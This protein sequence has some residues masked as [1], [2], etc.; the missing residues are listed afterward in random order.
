MT[1]TNGIVIE[2]QTRHSD[3]HYHSGVVSGSSASTLSRYYY[4]Y[5]HRELALRLFLALQLFSVVTWKWKTEVREEV[6]RTDRPMRC[7]SIH[8][9]ILALYM[10][11]IIP[12]LFTLPVHFFSSSSLITAVL[13]RFIHFAK[14]HD[15]LP[16]IRNSWGGY[17]VTT[18]ARVGK[19][20]PRSQMHGRR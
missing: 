11:G 13:E 3:A 18:G 17:F 4:I 20:R 12:R 6:H 9:V 16:C 10:A 8:I 14:L 7:N 15:T 5:Y 1:R 2:C 19:F